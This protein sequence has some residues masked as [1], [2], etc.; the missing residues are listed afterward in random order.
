MNYRSFEADELGN[1]A[2]QF[3]SRAGFDDNPQQLELQDYLSGFPTYQEYVVPRLEQFLV[4]VRSRSQDDLPKDP[5]ARA[6]Y[7]EA[8]LQGWHAYREEVEREWMEGFRAHLP[9]GTESRL[10]RYFTQNIATGIS[11]HLNKAGFRYAFQGHR[12]HKC[13]WRTTGSFEYYELGVYS[14]G[15]VRNNPEATVFDTKMDVAIALGITIQSASGIRI[16]TLVSYQNHD[17]YAVTNVSET[18][19]QNAGPDW[20]GWA[21]SASNGQVKEIKRSELLAC[22]QVHVAPAGVGAVLNI[23][24]TGTAASSRNF[25]TDVKQQ[26]CSRAMDTDH[27]TIPDNRDNCPNTPNTDQLD[28]DGDGY[29]DVCDNCPLQSNPEQADNDMD[30]VGNVCDANPNG[31]TDTGGGGGGSGGG[32]CC[33]TDP[34]DDRPNDG[35]TGGG[36]QNCNRTGGCVPPMICT[37]DGHCVLPVTGGGPGCCARWGIIH[38]IP[39]CLEWESCKTEHHPANASLFG[40]LDLGHMGTLVYDYDEN[41]FA[42]ESFEFL[43]SWTIGKTL[44]P[45]D[46]DFVLRELDR[47]ENW[48]DGDGMLTPSDWAWYR[49]YLWVDHNGD[50]LSE[51]SEWLSLDEAGFSEFP[52]STE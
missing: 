9:S 43:T 28:S 1:L 3:L 35:G 23:C 50:G 24:P 39:V 44:Y 19:N 5:D 32:G 37:Y 20:D 29:G 36:S 17:F 21:T 40:T 25:S 45:V 30:G 11:T 47:P 26:L 4:K 8:F 46:P 22:T 18:L 2:P 51:K 15:W 38:T 12:F 49:L 7:R 6:A 14:A 31:E 33:L 27:D 10:L 41:G 34:H 48:G 13:E 52:I 42:S 16:P